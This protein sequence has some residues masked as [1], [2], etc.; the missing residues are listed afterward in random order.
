M[1]FR[2]YSSRQ[3][4]DY[5]CKGCSK[6]LDC[7]QILRHLAG[8][9]RCQSSYSNDEMFE[10]KTQSTARAYARKRKAYDPAKRAIKYKEHVSKMKAEK[11]NSEITNHSQNSES[12]PQA[13][14]TSTKNKRIQCLSCKYYFM[15]SSILKHIGKSAKCKSVYDSPELRNE[16]QTL[17]TNAR[18]RPGK[19]LYYQ[20]IKK[21]TF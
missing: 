11:L 4:M 19:A 10:F 18:I 2:S 21:Q 20:K 13:R 9:K 1:C 17:L 8:S 3:I 12:K 14:M 6:N 16:Y 15:E 5:C 7:R